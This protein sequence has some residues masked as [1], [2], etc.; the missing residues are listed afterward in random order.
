MPYPMGLIAIS[1]PEVKKPMPRTISAAPTRNSKI[2]PE[3][4]G[5]K[6]TLEI[7]KIAVMGITDVKARMIFSLRILFMKLPWMGSS[8]RIIGDFSQKEK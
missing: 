1:T 8:G 3:D 6:I 7:K 2:V 5:T 4:M